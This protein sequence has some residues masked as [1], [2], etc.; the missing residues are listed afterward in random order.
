MCIT[1]NGTCLGSKSLLAPGAIVSVIQCSVGAPS[2]CQVCNASLTCDPDVSGTRSRQRAPRAPPPL[3]CPASAPRHG[4]R[5][6]ESARAW[7]RLNVGNPDSED[8]RF[9]KSFSQIPDTP[10]RPRESPPAIPLRSTR[11]L[12]GLYGNSLNFVLVYTESVSLAWS[13]MR[14]LC[15]S[16]VSSGGVGR[17]KATH[18]HRH[19]TSR[20]GG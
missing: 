4:A 6:D 2:E 15:R 12:R 19:T 20:I 16:Q 18:A 8:V 7:R 11:A 5:P 3:A 14:T 10:C 13:E 9:R 17:S 1:D